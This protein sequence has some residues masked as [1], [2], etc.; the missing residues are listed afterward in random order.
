MSFFYLNYFLGWSGFLLFTGISRDICVVWY[1]ELTHTYG[2]WIKS[3][4]FSPLKFYIA[5]PLLLWLAR[6]SAD[7]LGLIHSFDVGLVGFTSFL[8]FTTRFYKLHI[9]TSLFRV[10]IKLTLPIL[11]FLYLFSSYFISSSFR[12]PIPFILVARYMLRGFS[13]D[14]YVVWSFGSITSFQ[15]L[16]SISLD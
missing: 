3:N 14:W 1:E 16:L 13:Q 4:T 7:C 9:L 11:N 2:F 5:L 15:H 10:G 6:A 8:T 12:R